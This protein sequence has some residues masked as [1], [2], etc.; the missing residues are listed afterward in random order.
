LYPLSASQLKETGAVIHWGID[1]PKAIEQWADGIRLKE[2]W[3]FTQSEIVDKLGGYRVSFKIA[4]LFAVA[5]RAHRIL[6]YSL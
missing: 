6:Y 3:F 4:G 1:D 2:E 5:N